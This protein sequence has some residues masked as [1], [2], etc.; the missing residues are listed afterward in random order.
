ML[1]PVLRAMT[2]PCK[3]LKKVNIWEIFGST[4]YLAHQISLGERLP[5]GKFAIP[6]QDMGDLLGRRPDTAVFFPRQG[7]GLQTS[8]FA[9]S[10][11]LT[12]RVKSL[13]QIQMNP[14][15]TTPIHTSLPHR[16]SCINVIQ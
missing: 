1:S 7:V 15:Y 13:M 5:D 6:G 12:A 2:E 3:S 8:Q 9:N 10:N 4:D 14:L 11:S 16:L